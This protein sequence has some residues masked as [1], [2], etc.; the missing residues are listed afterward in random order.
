ME[1]T[2][3]ILTQASVNLFKINPKF[4]P[5]L[6][7]SIFLLYYVFRGTINQKKPLISHIHIYHKE[8]VLT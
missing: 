4:T 8:G 3:D 2:I 1:E 7:P 6:V 5:Q